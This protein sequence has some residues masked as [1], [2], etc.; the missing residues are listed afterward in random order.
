ML[1]LNN[2]SS[3]SSTPQNPKLWLLQSNNPCPQ[4]KVSH[5]TAKLQAPRRR[6]LWE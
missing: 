1:Q 3:V 4:K 2:V 6:K 5:L